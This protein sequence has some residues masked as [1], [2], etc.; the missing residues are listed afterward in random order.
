MVCHEKSR[1]SGRNFPSPETPEPA[2][3]H[4]IQCKLQPGHPGL[5]QTARWAWQ[6]LKNGGPLV[7]AN[8]KTGLRHGICKREVR[9]HPFR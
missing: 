9:G 2:M 4:L 1:A 3:P 8:E 7:F 5:L 6:G